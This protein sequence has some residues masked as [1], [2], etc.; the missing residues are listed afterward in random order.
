M[1]FGYETV[2]LVLISVVLMALSQLQVGQ[3]G[4]RWASWVLEQP[5]ESFLIPMV[6]HQRQVQSICPIDG[7]AKPIGLHPSVLQ[8]TPIGSMTVSFSQVWRLMNSLVHTSFPGMAGTRCFCPLS[9]SLSF[10]GHGHLSFMC[11]SLTSATS[12]RPEVLRHRLQVLKP[13]GQVLKPLPQFYTYVFLL[14]LSFHW[15]FSPV[16][17]G[18]QPM[19]LMDQLLSGQTH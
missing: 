17:L 1:G 8:Y 14:G 10:I 13:R 2:A 9:L 3:V 7:I 6:S 4:L 12:S 19:P 11:L 15:A 16:G 5:R 18:L